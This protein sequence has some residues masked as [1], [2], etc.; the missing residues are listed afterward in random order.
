MPPPWGK[1]ELTLGGGTLNVTLLLVT[2]LT[3]TCT[4][5]ALAVTGTIATICV[6]VQL[7]T[8]VAGCPLKVSV[9]LPWLPPKFVP[10]IV[11]EVP[12][13]PVVGDTPVMTG[14]LPPV[15]DTLSKM[16]VP[17][18]VVLPPTT[19]KPRYRFCAM[20]IVCAVPRCVQFAPSAE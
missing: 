18:A 4:G 1:Y 7:V 20:L 12:T 8:E 13:I 2:L 17:N 10:A 9:L 6:S 15:I 5:P 3:T 11:T 14:V 16:A 19:A